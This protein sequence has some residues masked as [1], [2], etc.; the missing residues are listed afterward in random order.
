MQC[1]A[2][3]KQNFQ[4]RMRKFIISAFVAKIPTRTQ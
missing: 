3:K 4:P 2:L 1:Y